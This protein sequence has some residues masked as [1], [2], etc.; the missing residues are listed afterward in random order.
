MLSVWLDLLMSSLYNLGALKFARFIRY[1]A[2]LNAKNYPLAAAEL[3]NS[4]WYHQVRRR[5]VALV[6]ILSKVK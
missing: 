1:I 3:K 4:R 5:G 6:G 2:A